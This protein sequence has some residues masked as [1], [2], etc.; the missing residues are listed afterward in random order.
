VKSVDEHLSDILSVVAPLSPMQVQLLDA[1]GCV[2]SEDVV[3]Q[4][5]MPPFDNSSMDGYAVHHED[6]ASASVQSPVSLH[7]TA[8]IPA[9]TDKVVHVR[10]GTAARIMTGAVMPSGADCVVPLEWTDDGIVDVSI[11]RP[12]KVGEYLRT[13]GSDVPAGTTVASVGT[14]LGPAQLGILA[15][16]GRDRVLVR[17]RPRVVVLATGSELVAPGHPLGVGQIPDS[18][19]VMLAAAARDAGAVVFSAGIVGDDPRELMRVLEDQLVR[20]DAVITSGGVS[21]GAYDVVK[22]A[23]QRLGTVEFDKVAMQP[24][25]PQGFGRIGPDET[26][27]F[28]LPGNPVSAFVSFEVFVRPALRRM[29]GVEPLERPQV[30]AVMQQGRPSPKGKR[31][32]LRGW[33]DVEDGRY[34]VA[35]VGGA[36]SHLQHGLSQANSLIV[37][38]EDIDQ[39]AEGDAVTVMMLERRAA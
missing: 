18:N 14:H 4:W 35:P 12:A 27:I 6:I 9:G 32:Y 16:A 2:L 30:R 38:P 34:V 8:D 31:Q 21:V 28:T 39:V 11:T 25:M 3:S 29:L 20:A 15:S 13:A 33:L 26:P 5:A 17:P 22:Q 24:G 1:H 19:S 10:Q 7:V 36:S 23:F 37:L